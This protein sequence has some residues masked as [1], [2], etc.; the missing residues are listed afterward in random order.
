MKSCSA[1]FNWTLND[2]PKRCTTKGGRWNAWRN[3]MAA[4]TMLASAHKVSQSPVCET[5]C[6]RHF[7]WGHSRKETW[8]LRLLTTWTLGELAK[9]LVN[10]LAIFER[11]LCCRRSA[12]YIISLFETQQQVSCIQATCINPD[13]SFAPAQL[14]ITSMCAWTRQDICI[15]D[16]EL[17]L[18]LV[19]FVW[20]VLRRRSLVPQDWEAPQLVQAMEH[21]RWRSPAIGR[22]SGKSH[23]R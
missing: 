13:I 10:W 17:A 4:T 23:D 2:I 6:N 5:Q 16:S 14:Y 22:L 1:V 11:H 3:K 19:T 18:L 15:C 12:V 21:L 8:L 7:L 9:P 20:W